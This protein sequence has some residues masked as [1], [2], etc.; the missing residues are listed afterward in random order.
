M[1]YY[2]PIFVGSQPFMTEPYA[3]MQG[4]QTSGVTSQDMT[5]GQPIPEPFREPME[6][7]EFPYYFEN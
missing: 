1:G 4:F 7:Y 3:G 6:N 2:S 5:P